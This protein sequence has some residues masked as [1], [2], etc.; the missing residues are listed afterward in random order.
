LELTRRAF[1]EGKHDEEGPFPT[2]SV[3]PRRKPDKEAE[4][5]GEGTDEEFHSYQ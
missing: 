5:R 3:S 4:T 1:E 2:R